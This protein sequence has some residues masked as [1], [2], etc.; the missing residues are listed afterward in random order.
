MREVRASDAAS[1]GGAAGG[2]WAFQEGKVELVRAAVVS[3]E[4]L[5]AEIEEVILIRQILGD[6]HPVSDAE[7]QQIVEVKA[8]AA[9]IWEKVAD[10]MEEAAEQLTQQLAM[11]NVPAG[12]VQVNALMLDDA[13]QYSQFSTRFR[14]VLEHAFQAHTRL[15]PLLAKEL[16]FTSSSAR[17]SR[18]RPATNKT[19]YLLYGSSFV[20]EKDGEVSPNTNLS[21]AETGETVATAAARLKREAVRNLEG[22]PQN[23]TKALEDRQVFGQ[24]EILGGSLNLEVWTSHAVDGLALEERTGFKG[25]VRVNKPAYLRFLYHLRNGVRTL[26]DRLHLNDYLGTEL[27]NKVV[28]L[29]DTLTVSP[30]LGSEGMPFFASDQPLPEV[31]LIRTRFG[32]EDFDVQA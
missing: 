15:R 1:Q 26:P 21:R 2:Q 28:T 13:Y 29:P 12:K 31:R 16:D 32:Q 18:L 7:L 25:A 30:P 14:V 23:F 4:K 22:H 11:Q 10:S 20:C 8:K 3:C 5:V 6:S 24:D 17:M 27:V 9:E 19:D